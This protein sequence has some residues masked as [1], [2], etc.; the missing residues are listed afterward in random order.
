MQ[1]LYPILLAP[2]TL[3][4]KRAGGKLE[5]SDPSRTGQPSPWNAQRSEV[6][7]VSTLS[8]S[9]PRAPNP[10]EA[11]GPREGFPAPL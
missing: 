11:P 2:I 6:C 1:L 4:R 3:T 8:T 7:P 9:G 5:I 10:A